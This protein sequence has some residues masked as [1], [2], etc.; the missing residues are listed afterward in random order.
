MVIVGDTHLHKG[1]HTM[2]VQV[3]YEWAATT[4]EPWSGRQRTFTGS[5]L[6]PECADPMPEAVR[7]AEA[8]TPYGYQLERDTVSVW[9]A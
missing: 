9:E 4:Y 1:T 3:C 2:Q 5:F 7:R 8:A 6:A